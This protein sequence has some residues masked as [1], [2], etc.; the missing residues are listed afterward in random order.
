M[1]REWLLSSTRS[2]VEPDRTVHSTNTGDFS[3]RSPGLSFTGFRGSSLGI[4]RS[5][6][7]V[8]RLSTRFTARLRSTRAA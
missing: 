4:F 8:A 2:N 5:S 3:S 7:P 6:Y 1:E